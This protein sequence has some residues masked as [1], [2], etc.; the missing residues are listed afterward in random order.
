MSWQEVAIF[1]SGYQRPIIPDL[2][3][4]STIKGTCHTKYGEVSLSNCSFLAR[5][6][7]RSPHD[8]SI[9]LLKMRGTMALLRLPCW[10]LIKAI[11]S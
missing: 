9:N 5:R 7:N 8:N 2:H 1:P 10:K 6:V 3:I 4:L 11:V